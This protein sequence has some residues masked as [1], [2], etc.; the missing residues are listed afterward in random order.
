M[1][2][3]LRKVN[4]EQQRL[5]QGLPSLAT[6]SPAPPPK[7]R[8]NWGLLT[9]YC[10]L[11]WLESQ[12]LKV[13][14]VLWKSPGLNWSMSLLCSIPELVLLWSWGSSFPSSPV[15]FSVKKKKKNKGFDCRQLFL[16][17]GCNHSP[18]AYSLWVLVLPSETTKSKLSDLGQPLGGLKTKTMS[19]CLS[20]LG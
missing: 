7:G 16:M 11:R 5:S 9:E 17:S 19:L 18:S 13:R 10:S 14:R 8:L 4:E 15:L 6:H 1:L 12:I 2:T 3:C 20:F